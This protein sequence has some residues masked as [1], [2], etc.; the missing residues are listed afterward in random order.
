[1][2]LSVEHS[3]ARYNMPNCKERAEACRSV[4]KRAEACS[5]QELMKLFM[6][7]KANHVVRFWGLSRDQ[8]VRIV[9]YM[10]NHEKNDDDDSAPKIG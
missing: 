8:D 4:Q 1:M 9:W 7:R 5:I 3:E 10:Y 6:L 2:G